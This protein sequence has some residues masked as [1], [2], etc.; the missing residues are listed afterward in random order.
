MKKLFAVI[1]IFYSIQT[2]SQGWTS[3]TPFSS[4]ILS[5]IYM[6]DSATAYVG[7]NNYSLYKTIDGGDSWN[8]L[9]N[10]ILYRIND[11]Y[12]PSQNVGYAAGSSIYYGIKS[13]DGGVT[14]TNFYIDSIFYRIVKIQFFNND[15]GVFLGENGYVYKTL[16][17]GNSFIRYN[18]PSDTLCC[19]DMYFL[20]ENLGF[21][22]DRD[23][24]YRTIDGGTTWV[25]TQ[26]TINGELE[27]FHFIDSVGYIVGYDNGIGL[28]LKT[29]DY[30]VTWSQLSITNFDLLGEVYFHDQLWGQVLSRNSYSSYTT[31]DGGLTWFEESLPIGGYI[32]EMDFYNCKGFIV[33]NNGQI[34]RTNQCGLS[35]M[36]HAGNDINLFCNESITLNPTITYLGLDSLTYSWSPSYGLSDATILNPVANPAVTTTYTINVTDGYVNSTDSLTIYVGK[37]P[38]QEICMVTVDSSSGK[39]QIIWEKA[40]LPIESYYIWKETV[41][42]G[43][44][45][46][47]EAVPSSSAGEYI[48]IASEPNVQS[49]KYK[50][51]V[52]DSCGYIS[53]MCS[54]HKTLHLNVSP[55]IPQGYA[56]TWE[57]YEGFSFGTYVIYR[58]SD[59]AN[60]DSIAAISYSPGTYTYA[61][62]NNLTERYYMIAA[63]KTDTCLIESGNKSYTSYNK[64]ISNIVD[65]N[66]NSFNDSDLPKNFLTSPNPFS[67]KI[68]FIFE[69][70]SIYEIRILNIL[71]KEVYSTRL[72]GNSYTVSTSEL[73]AGTY[74]IQV[75]SAEGVGV[76]KMV[77]Q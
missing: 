67:E 76:K 63:I 25:A 13:I 11:I 39:N 48:D 69:N 57:H 7:G 31:M 5:A 50:I 64:T 58:G 53:D 68:G 3:L 8:L 43:T 36:V 41:I 70:N 21:V 6:T 20:N 27:A 32:R 17:G 74:L 12:F 18:T 24:I 2:Y 77:K 9:N 59:Y 44:Y 23:A 1:V 33:G 65:V 16:D 60:M 47:L 54:Y 61:D 45:N 62:I 28:I 30:G 29:D 37:L 34:C 52:L 19:R 15:T 4:D 73:P 49:N 71:G 22:L 51:S 46:L 38:E 42:A 55:A 26:I 35:T 40:Q 75:K 10:T 66:D 56:L 72:R 14:W